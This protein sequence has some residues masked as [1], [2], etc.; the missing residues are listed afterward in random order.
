MAK[1]MEN[2]SSDFDGVIYESYNDDKNWWDV[3]GAQSFLD[4]GKLVV[5]N[6]YNEIDCDK[7]YT[8][9]MNDYNTD[10]SFI[11][12]DAKLKKYVH[13]NDE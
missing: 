3:E 1:N 5:I 8:D 13:Y 9:Y 11:C 12:E 6:H 10:L 4:A 7:V 2:G